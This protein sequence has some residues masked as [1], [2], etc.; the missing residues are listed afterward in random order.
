MVEWRVAL[1]TRIAAA[2][3]LSI[4]RYAMPDLAMSASLV[5]AILAI[6]CVF[7]AMVAAAFYLAASEHDYLDQQDREPAA[8]PAASR[9]AAR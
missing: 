8:G 1:F 2:A 9:I 4:G 3:T 7:G 6:L 5:A